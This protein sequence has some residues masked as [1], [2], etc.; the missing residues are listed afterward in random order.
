[1]DAAIK[2]E[3]QQRLRHPRIAHMS[4][5]PYSTLVYS[6]VTSQSTTNTSHPLIRSLTKDSITRLLVIGQLPRA[7]TSVLRS[8]PI[9]VTIYTGTIDGSYDAIYVA[10]LGDIA[11]LLD[12]EVRLLARIVYTGSDERLTYA[13]RLMGWRSIRPSTWGVNNT[14][15]ASRLP[16][17]RAVVSYTDPPIAYLLTAQHPRLA[18]ANYG[19]T[20]VTSEHIG[21]RKLLVNELY[22]LTQVLHPSDSVTV[23]Y[24]G[25]APGYHL[26]ASLWLFPNVKWILYDSRKCQLPTDPR[27]TFH[28]RY[29]A[30]EDARDYT[31]QGVIFIS[32]IRRTGV[33]NG[34]A[35]HHS[36]IDE[37]MRLQEAWVRVMKPRLAMLKFRLPYGETSYNYLAGD[38]LLQ[39]YARSDSTETRLIVSNPT[40]NY[41]YNPSVYEEQLAYHNM[42]NR[43][44]S[45]Y[46]T[47]TEEELY[48]RWIELTNSKLSVSD[49]VRGIVAATMA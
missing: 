18:Y 48:R 43:P 11:P 36:A 12:V 3:V 25:A 14:V 37:D 15:P 40:S 13:A 20:T 1:M 26:T 7:V 19:I 17:L 34:V 33:E 21:Q 23:V 8:M 41:T 4:L 2:P 45:N 10:T 47:V 28:Q 6:S 16:L 29:F 49:A 22:L 35:T 44:L 32:D 42:V 30:L 46:D 38:I 24:V 5:L 27:I 31:G 39:P 9:T